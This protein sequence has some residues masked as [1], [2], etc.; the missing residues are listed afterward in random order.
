MCLAAYFN[1]IGCLKYLFD[2]TH[3]PILKGVFDVGIWA[4]NLLSSL[5]SSIFIGLGW[6]WVGFLKQSSDTEMGEVGSGFFSGTTS[7]VEKWPCNRWRQIAPVLTFQL[8][9][10]YISQPFRHGKRIVVQLNTWQHLETPY[11]TK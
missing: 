7:A 3:L 8:L 6:N 11:R 5:L 9:V 4:H 10:S 2:C 1:Y